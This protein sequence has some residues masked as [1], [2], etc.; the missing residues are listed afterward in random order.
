VQDLPVPGDALNTRTAG[1]STDNSWIDDDRV[2]NFERL[3]E[4]AN[5]IAECDLTGA[6]V[7]AHARGLTPY[8][9]NSS[10]TVFGTYGRADR[11]HHPALW[12][13]G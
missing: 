7:G 10:G 6:R 1:S 5:Q 2:L 11:Q 13:C 12:V 8:G 4:R 3:G 9:R